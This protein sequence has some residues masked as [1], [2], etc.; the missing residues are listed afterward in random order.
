MSV[1]VLVFCWMILPVDMA[2]ELND[3]FFKS[4]CSPHAAKY[5]DGRD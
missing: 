1:G 4:V 2:K 3:Y 5:M